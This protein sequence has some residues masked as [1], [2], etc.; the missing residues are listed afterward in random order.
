MVNETKNPGTYEVSW[1][2]T[3]KASGVYFYRLTGGSLVETRKLVFL[4]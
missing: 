2:A 3:G 4:R 1:D